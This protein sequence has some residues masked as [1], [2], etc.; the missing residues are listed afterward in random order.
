MED[1]LKEQFDCSHEGTVN[2]QSV[3]N[4]RYKSPSLSST[5]IVVLSD[6]DWGCRAVKN[7][8]K[9]SMFPDTV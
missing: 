2:L 1:K 9:P 5:T 4:T 3:R 6:S 8:G 7:A